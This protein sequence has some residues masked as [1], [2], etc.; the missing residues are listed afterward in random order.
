MKYLVKNRLRSFSAPECGDR[1][2]TLVIASV[3]SS[4]EKDLLDIEVKKAEIAVRVGARAVTDHSFYGDIPSYHRRLI[5]ELPVAVSAVSNYEWAARVREEQRHW[6]SSDSKLAI[7]VLAEQ[8]ARGIDMLTVH[9]SLRQKDLEDIKKSPR[10]IPMTSKGGGIVAAYMRATGLE[11]PYYERFDEVLEIARDYEIVLSLGTSLRPA[12]VCDQFDQLFLIELLAM[13]ELTQRALEKGV[14]V[15]IEGIGHATLSDT[16]RYVRMTKDLCFG[17]PYRVLPMA[18]DIA[19]GYDHISGALGTAVA[20][21]AGADAVTCISRAEHIG[22]PT[23]AD[24]EEAVIAT[25]IAT[26]AAQLGDVVSLDKDRQMAMTRWMQG[27]KGDWTTA[28]YPAG[29]ADAL[30]R[31]GRYQDQLVQCSMCGEYCGIAAGISTTKKRASIEIKSMD[32]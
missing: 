20:V 3:G 9:S 10:L 22:L 5:S 25:R 8:A 15:M 6:T 13:Q 12:T 2:E 16:S 28:I 18:T 19:L 30:K 1:C 31:Y 11:N 24:I 26:H 29:A 7:N 23:D 4:G 17:V 32:K 21:M 27:C 14:K